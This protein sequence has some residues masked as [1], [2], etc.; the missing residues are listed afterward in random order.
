MLQRR[1]L[2]RLCVY[3]DNLQSLRVFRSSGTLFRASAAH[4]SL[5]TAPALFTLGE[6]SVPWTGLSLC[7]HLNRSQARQC[8]SATCPVTGQACMVSLDEAG[9][10]FLSGP[11]PINERLSHLGPQN[12]KGHR[13]RGPAQQKTV[14]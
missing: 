8:A 13:D 2:T 5:C 6:F 4:I 3:C 11:K 7:G 1:A 14:V 12:F 9:L 10:H